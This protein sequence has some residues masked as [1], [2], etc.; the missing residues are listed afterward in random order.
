MYIVAPL[1]IR[2]SENP[3]LD[4]GILIKVSDRGFG[5]DPGS[6]SALCEERKLPVRYDKKVG[7]ISVATRGLPASSKELKIL[8][9]GLFG[10]WPEGKIPARVPEIMFQCLL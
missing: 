7:L 3:D 2:K 10:N 6:L 9:S 8:V 5:I 4:E 1:I